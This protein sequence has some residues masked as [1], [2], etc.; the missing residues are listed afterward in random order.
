MPDQVSWVRQSHPPPTTASQPPPASVPA[1]APAPATDDY[2][3]DSPYG[4]GSAEDTIGANNL[5]SVQDLLY[6]FG[7]NNS[8]QAAL[9]KCGDWTLIASGRRACCAV[10]LINEPCREFRIWLRCCRALERHL[11]ARTRASRSAAEPNPSH[12]RV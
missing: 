7:N 9:N 2:E 4:G 5:N 8:Q 12:K 11:T 3:G 10:A 1:L 6:I